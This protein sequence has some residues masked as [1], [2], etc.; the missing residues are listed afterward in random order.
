MD[1]EMDVSGS[2]GLCLHCGKQTMFRMRAK[3]LHIGYED[4]P[5]I[6]GVK[7]NARIKW[8]LLQCSECLKP[9]L[10]QADENPQ[11]EYFGSKIHKKKIETL[12]PPEKRISPSLPET[13]RRRY[14]E[15][16][17]VQTLSPSSCAVLVRRTLE[18]VCQYENATGKTLAD[19]L[20]N[21][22]DTGKIPQTLADVA[23]HLR[24]LGNLAAHHDV[25]DDVTIEDVP[26]ILDFIDLFLGYLYVTPAKIQAM[27]DRLN[28]P[29]KDN[30]LE[31]DILDDNPF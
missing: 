15:A 14:A 4:H 23:L 6:G 25:N 30:S 13:V 29:Q 19:Q 28:N 7:E 16:I 27:K 17:K 24:Q 22:A 2:P 10:I 3:Y 9:I 31:I 12:Y 21:L 5:A 18:A 20:K 8:T 11:R 26:I 1:E